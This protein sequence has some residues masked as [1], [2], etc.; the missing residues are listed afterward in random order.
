M[1][2]RVIHW[3]DEPEEKDFPAA[4]SYLSL[5]FEPEVAQK[6]ANALRQAPA[7]AFAAKDV[8]RASGATPAE[9]RGYDLKA[10]Q[11]AIAGR[12]PLSPILLVRDSRSHR[13]IVAD[14]FHRLC[15]VFLENEDASVPC[16]ILS[17]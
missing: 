12:Q 9:A 2:K 13:L 4:A 3:R 14:G 6:L 11:D 10:Q 7:C 16:R 17:A 8:L 5:V 15:A 1:A